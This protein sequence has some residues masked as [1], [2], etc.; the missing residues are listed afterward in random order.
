MA[1][2]TMARKH[3]RHGQCRGAFCSPALAIACASL[4]GRWD[5]GVATSS[6]A[7]VPPVVQMSS[8]LT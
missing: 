7:C 3:K 6:R 2:G 1:A 5:F 8:F 4:L